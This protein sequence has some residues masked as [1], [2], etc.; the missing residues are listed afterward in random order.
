MLHRGEIGGRYGI[1]FPEEIDAGNLKDV[2]ILVVVCVDD[3]P[4]NSA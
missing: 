2:G 1:T 4:Y 3:V